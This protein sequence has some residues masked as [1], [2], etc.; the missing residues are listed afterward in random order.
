MATPRRLLFLLHKHW[1]IFEQLCRQ[2]RDMPFFTIEYILNLIELYS[3]KDADAPETVLNALCAADLLQV[4]NRTDC[5][6]VNQL[7]L[8][9]VRGLT[10]EHELGLSEVLKARINGLMQSTEQ[11]A[12]SLK[13]N[14]M[15]N[16][17]YGTQRLSEILRQI[18]QQLEHDRHAIMGLA[19][20]A[21]SSD[22]SIPIAQRY[23]QVLDAYD[24][25]V[26]PMNAMMDSSLG[27]TFYPYLEQAIDI[28]DQAEELL[29]VRGALYHDRR[30]LRSVTHQAK[31]LQRQ[32]RLTAQKCADT[33]LPLRDELRQ[34]NQLS[35]AVSSI[36]GRVRKKGLNRALS[37]RDIP[38]PSW[39]RERRERLHLDGE[40]REL[41]AAARD[42]EPVVYQFPEALSIEK[43]QS[44]PRVDE[45]H[46]RGKL[47]QSLPVDNLL[48]WLQE[49]YPRLSDSNWLRLYHS[50]VQENTWHAALQSQRVHTDLNQ[51]RVRYHP[52]KLEKPKEISKQ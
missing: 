38:I 14:E 5:F 26:E 7:V 23:K 36:L 20:Q 43:L 29:S 18:S 45:A 3:G 15:D 2:S 8:D 21:K 41:M 13:L 34:N 19:E 27:G 42:F 30:Y 28:L 37:Y 16:L 52:H 22:T 33:L 32:G 35:A 25:Y 48:V 40:V 31:E 6:Q 49:N 51:I 11:I 9:F 17:R 50:L 10:H 1:N 4:P 44:E 47:K 39:R 24:Q 12:Q 46:L